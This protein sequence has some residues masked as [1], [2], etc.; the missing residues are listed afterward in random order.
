MKF[1][2]IN[3]DDSC[4]IAETAS[5]FEIQILTS[6]RDGLMGSSYLKVSL[7]LMSEATF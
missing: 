6:I 5:E 3:K 7:L 4:S 2:Y 1:I